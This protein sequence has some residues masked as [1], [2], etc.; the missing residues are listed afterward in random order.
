M[1][2]SRSGH[3]PSQI[4]VRHLTQVRRATI[5]H[6]MNTVGET[7]VAGGTLRGGRLMAKIGRRHVHERIVLSGFLIPGNH[8]RRRCGKWPQT[9]E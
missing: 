1:A 5:C 2:A 3:S 8:R 9:N 6:H 7:D 4:P